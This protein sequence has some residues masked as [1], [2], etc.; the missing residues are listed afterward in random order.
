MTVIPHAT[1]AVGA[2]RGGRRAF[3]PRG[4]AEADPL[5]SPH[6]ACAAPT[7]RR[8]G[9]GRNRH[10]RDVHRLRLRRRRRVARPQ[11]AVDAGQPGARRARGPARAAGHRRCPIA[12]TSPTARRSRPTRCWSGAARASSLLTTAGFEDVLEIGRQTRPELYALEPRRRSRWWRGGVASASRERHGVRR[13]TSLQPL[14]TAAM[15]RAVRSGAAAPAPKSVAVCL[16]HA[17]ANRRARAP[18]RPR[19][20]GGSAVDC[21]AVARAG[22]AS[23]ASTSAPARR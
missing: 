23:T 6:A 9:A 11:A 16:L 13:R 14:T 17:Y 10:R 1:A 2:S 5:D 21:H 7:P 4:V 12:S 3:G 20:R 8:I 15:R 19:A 22:R 18:A